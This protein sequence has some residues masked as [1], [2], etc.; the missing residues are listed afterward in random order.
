MPV[1][2]LGYLR[3]MDSRRVSLFG[4]RWR[5]F[6]QG[7][8]H[9]VSANWLRKQCTGIYST[10]G[11]FLQS[12]HSPAQI[13]TQSLLEGE[14]VF[15]S[16]LEKKSGANYEKNFDCEVGLASFLYAYILTSKPLTVIETGVANGI[17][18]NTMMKALEQTGGALH[19][20]DIDARTQNVYTG[21]G[22]WSFY[23]L[24]GNLEKSLEAHVTEIGDVDLW[25]HDSNHGYLWQAYEYQLA[26]RVLTTDGVL[27]SDDIDS[28]TAWGLASKDFL[29]PSSA[30][31][32]SRKFIGV[33]KIR[34]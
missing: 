9:G 33:A 3:G 28:S 2:K 12:E 24:N 20:F 19:S 6:S 31:F 16:I 17:T 15:R 5:Y 4:Q 18:T 13:S 26:S 1:L 21:T 30:I 25:I 22:N 34:T 8:I 27:V 32:D 14:Q 11:E 10:V 23:H 29:E 7:N